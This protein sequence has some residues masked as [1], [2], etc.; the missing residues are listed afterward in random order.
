MLGG[1]EL[2]GLRKLTTIGVHWT[3]TCVGNGSSGWALLNSHLTF[4]ERTP[5]VVTL[6]HA[7]SW[8]GFC[9]F[10]GTQVLAMPQ[11]VSFLQSL[12]LAQ[13]ECGTQVPCE[14]TSFEGAQ[15]GAQS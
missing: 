5:A 9:P 10:H 15:G 3:C 7:G 14:Q 11:V 13:D 1:P 2:A 6:M 8:A 12:S 4:G